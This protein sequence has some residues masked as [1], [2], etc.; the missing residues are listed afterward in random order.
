MIEEVAAERRTSAVGH[1]AGRKDQS[2]PASL[3]CE[4]QRTFDKQ[5]IP[6]DV[7]TGL[8][9]VD[10]RLANEARE[11]SRVRPPKKEGA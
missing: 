3:S 10:A 8:D 4:L 1:R 2:D 5:L 9:A 6:I 7:R 11:L